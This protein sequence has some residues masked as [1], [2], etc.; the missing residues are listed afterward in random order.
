MRF[1]RKEIRK[2]IPGLLV[3]ILI[4]AIVGFLLMI[5]LDGQQEPVARID[6]GSDEFRAN[7]A[8]IFDGTGSMDPDGSDDDLKFRWT[9]D[10]KDAGNQDKLEYFFR[11]SGNHTVVLKVTDPTGR[12]DSDTISITVA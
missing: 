9:V 4:I 7:T 10:D 12:S 11:E 8:I 6:V 1:P 5:S 2:L 3:S